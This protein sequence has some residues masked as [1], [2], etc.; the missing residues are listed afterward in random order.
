MSENTE[1][2]NEGGQTAAEQNTA[3]QQQPAPRNDAEAEQQEAERQAR[4]EA[5]AAKKPKPDDQQLERKRNRTAAYIE[6]LQAEN[7]QLRRNQR[8]ET[9]RQA[10]PQQPAKEPSL[11]EHGFDPVAYARA[12][13]QYEVQQALAQRDQQQHTKAETD[14]Q[15][16]LLSSYQQ[17]AA[18]FAADHDDYVEVVGSMDP[19]LLTQG[20]Q[21]AIMAHEK[22]P[23]IAY[24]LAQDDDGLFA[25]ASTRPELLARAIARYAERMSGAQSSQTP[26]PAAAPAALATTTQPAKPISQAPAPPPRVSGRSPTEAPP[27]KLTDDEWYERE[28][29][30]RRAR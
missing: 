27:E 20:L 11:E 28:Q 4:E 9:P 26:P 13:A 6:R 29:E 10:Q 15:E 2:L 24:Q 21:A 14:R 25:L 18:A 30:K 17:R 7:A 19:E 22:G 12:Y 23:E 1:A 16:Q 8:E 3:T 5:E